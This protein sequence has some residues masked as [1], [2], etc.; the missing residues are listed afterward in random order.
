M[1]VL[2]C[3]R[4]SVVVATFE[5]GPYEKLQGAG[6]GVTELRGIPTLTE[7]PRSGG[8]VTFER[9]TFRPAPEG[10]WMCDSHDQAPP[11]DRRV[12]IHEQYRGES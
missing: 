6:I 8:T 1:S 3:P 4:C 9:G 2:R 7:W 5:P 12:A 10:G 11:S